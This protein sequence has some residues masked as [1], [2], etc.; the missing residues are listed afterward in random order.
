MTVK[1]LSKKTWLIVI[2]IG[3]LFFSGLLFYLIPINSARSAPALKI[4]DQV[5]PTLPKE[6]PANSELSSLPIRLKISKINLDAAIE[7][8]GMTSEG[9]MSV[10][11]NHAN[12]AWFNLGPRPGEKGSAVIDGHFGWWK[13]NRPTVFN[14][15]YKLRK[16]DKIYIRDAEGIMITFVVREFKIYDPQADA[17]DVFTSAD[18]KSH[19]NLITCEGA[20][21]KISQSYSKRLIVF[22]DKEN[23]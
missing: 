5:T 2:L 4:K 11:K 23:E 10:P 17:V 8:V 14:N 12:V 20:W 9:A 6:K 16:G 18:G 1:I 19:L 15:L 7:S 13:N 21:D 3:L 22:A